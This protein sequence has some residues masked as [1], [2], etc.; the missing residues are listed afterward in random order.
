MPWHGVIAG[1]MHYVHRAFIDLVL[2]RGDAEADAV[3]IRIGLPEPLCTAMRVA[4]W[5]PIVTDRIAK[6]RLKASSLLTDEDVWVR[7]SE[8]IEVRAVEKLRK[9]IA[10]RPLM[11]APVG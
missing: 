1:D 4:V 9:W 11:P 5:R 8:E 7:W 6:R 10:N 3:G 2:S